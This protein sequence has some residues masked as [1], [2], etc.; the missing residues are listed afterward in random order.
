MK[1]FKYKITIIALFLY[2]LEYAQTMESIKSAD[3][4]YIYFDH[5][6]FQKAKN[7]NVNSDKLLEEIKIYEIRVD[8]I[9]FINFSERKYKDFDEYERK[10]ELERKIISKKKL[11]QEKNAIIDINFIK[12]YGLEEVYFAIY[13]KKIFL[14][15]SKEIFKRKV[16]LKE[17]VFGLA[18]YSFEE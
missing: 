15:D 5:S 16:I 12:K 3:T 7:P 8:S 4:V 13:Y 6:D 9:N 10:N 11:K 1:N 17:V 14:I 2:H 18:S